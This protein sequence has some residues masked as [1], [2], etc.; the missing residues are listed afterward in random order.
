MK[1]ST[2]VAII[3]ATGAVVLATLAFLSKKKKSLCECGCD[4][5]NTNDCAVDEEYDDEFL[6]V[7]D[8]DEVV[9]VPET[10]VEPAQVDNVDDA[11]DEGD[12]STKIV[13]D[14]G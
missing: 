11:E 8:M 2:I 4:M 12:D 6:Y 9:K 5:E 1:A 3:L 14:M 10:P 13:A 7:D